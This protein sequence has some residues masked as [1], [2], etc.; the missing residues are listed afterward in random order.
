M[1]K[2]ILTVRPG[3]KSFV[4]IEAEIIA[5]KTFLSDY[6]SCTVWRG[7]REL[8]LSEVF[9]IACEGV[10]V[11]EDD[12]E[13]ILRG[14]TSKIK[15]V[16]EYMDGGKITIEG[17]IGMHCGNFMSNGTIEIH[18]NADGWLGREMTGGH[19]ICHGNAGHYCGSGYRGEKNGM[20]GGII[21][22]FKDAGDFCAECLSGGEVIVKGS[23]GDMAGVDMKDGIL[24][25]YGDCTRLCGNMKGGIATVFGTVHGMMPTFRKQ[26][27]VVVEGR[28]MSCFMGDV[29]NRGK[30]TLQ[31]S[32]YDFL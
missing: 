8:L 18:G 16:G 22:V 31:I 1:M 9:D 27:D 32:E 7:N 6:S 26:D 17:D 19:I 14:D 3:E 29:G 21:E 20:S 24:T 2:V 15:R 13:I 11:S 30:G 4:P 12:V 28:T 23:C 10:A 5:P 25:I